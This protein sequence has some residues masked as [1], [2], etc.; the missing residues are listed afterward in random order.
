[1]CVAVNYEFEGKDCIPYFPNPY[2]TLPVLRKSGDI[3]LL[4]WG[5]RQS[6]TGNLPLGGWARL[7]SIQK[8]VWDKYFAKPVKLLITRF[9]EKDIE[10]K[11]QWFALEKGQF[12]Q[13][14][15][16]QYDDECRVYI[17]TISPEGQ[18]AAHERWPRILMQP[19]Y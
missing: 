9:A 17:V 19:C 3:Q 11:S 6:Q 18:H 14:L 8:G 13:G 4:P 2:A 15:L 7:E 1:M 5:R 12:I 16:A 10:G